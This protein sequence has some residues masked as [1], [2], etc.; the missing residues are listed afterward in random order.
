MSY[1][2]Y[3]RLSS[4][5]VP[6]QNAGT[7]TTYAYNAD[8]TINSVTDARGASATYIYNNGRHLVNGINYN[9]PSGITPTSNVTFG[10]DAVGNRTLM[11]DG[12]GRQSYFYDSLSRMTSETRTFN[13][14]PNSFTL[15]YGYNLAG[16]LT[17]LTDPFNG[18]VTYQRDSSGRVQSMGANGYSAY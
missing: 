7:A 15:T 11:N 1:D 3:G 16:Q 13:A 5:H 4:K 2:G 18:Q 14:L 17:S 12:L 6:E 8:D 10:Y 9:A